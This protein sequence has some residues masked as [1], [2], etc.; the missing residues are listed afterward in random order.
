M[1]LGSG[2]TTD[3]TAGGGGAIIINVVGTTTINGSIIVDGKSVSGASGSGGSGGSVF[4]N[5]SLLIGNG[6]ISAN[7]GVATYD[8]GT[9]GGSR[10]AIILTNGTTF[11]NLTI[12]SH[13]WGVGSASNGAAGTIYLKKSNQIFG[14]LIIDNKGALT[15]SDVTT[16]IWQNITNTI[17]GS[18]HLINSSRLNVSNAPLTIYGD[19]NNTKGNFTAD[20]NSTIIFAGNGLSNTTL[21]SN[22]TFFNLNITK[23]KEYVFFPG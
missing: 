5:T 10:I 1:N 13:G 17:I 15:Y 18:L 14:D 4:L 6:T 20:T 22:E 12:N 2:A 23:A 3:G 11:G 16:F 7:G 19:F 9:G 21:Y 8:R